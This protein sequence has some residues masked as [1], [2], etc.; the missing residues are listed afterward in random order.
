V[1]VKWTLLANRVQARLQQMTLA[2]ADKS[3]ALG[4]LGNV[5][6]NRIRLGFRMGR[7]PWGNPW[8]PLNPRFRTGQPLRDTGRLQ[9]SITSQVQGDAVVV[10]TN[11]RYARTHQYGATILPKNGDVLAF[12]IKAAGGGMAFLKSAKIP[13]RPFMPL[14]G[15]QV[16]LPQ[17]WA[18]SGLKAMAKA[19]GLDGAGVPIQ[20]GDQ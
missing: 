16:N 18:R 19:M 14:S 9:R 11:V 8:K 12:P 6:A 2:G 7:D 17:A 10:G 4:A 20:G 3:R 5:L 13:A 15:N 1:N